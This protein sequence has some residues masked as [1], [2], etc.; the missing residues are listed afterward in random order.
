MIFSEDCE[1]KNWSEEG[2]TSSWL[3]DSEDP[4]RAGGA[5]PR[6]HGGRGDFR[7]VGFW[8]IANGQSKL[9]SARITLPS[10]DLRRRSKAQVHDV[11]PRSAW[12]RGFG[13][14]RA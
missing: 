6:S 11:F 8:G 7:A 3:R 10:N 4:A 5:R 9:P 12:L 14:R 13:A 2:R 1:N